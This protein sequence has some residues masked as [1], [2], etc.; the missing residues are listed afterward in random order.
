MT[1]ES[2]TVEFINAPWSAAEVDA[3]N[4]FQRADHV[5]PF[6]CPHHTDNINR[7]LFATSAGWLC[8]HCAYQQDWAHRAMLAEPDTP[9]LTCDVCLPPATLIRKGCE[10]EV[11]MVALR[12]REFWDAAECR[13]ADPKALLPQIDPAQIGELGETNQSPVRD[14]IL[15]L[16]EVARYHPSYPQVCHA[17][18]NL[19]DHLSAI[20]FAE[21]VNRRHQDVGEQRFR[22]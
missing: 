17:L 13:F 12:A 14:L 11:L 15:K 16:D 2:N 3:L 20:A 7:T 4:R 21:E 10:I 5:H 19:R 8:P 6:T 1:D 9:K 18:S 22:R